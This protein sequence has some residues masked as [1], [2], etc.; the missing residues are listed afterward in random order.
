MFRS[1]AWLAASFLLSAVTFSPAQDT[2]DPLT[3]RQPARRV[4][5]RAAGQ[6]GKPSTARDSAPSES[7]FL[8]E[9]IPAADDAA[10]GSLGTD[11]PDRSEMDLNAVGG[12]AAGKADKAVGGASSD[13]TAAAK[14]SAAPPEAW[15]F[16]SHQNHLW[17]YHP[18]RQW[19]YWDNDHWRTFRPAVASTLPRNDSAAPGYQSGYRGLDRAGAAS[20]KG[21]GAAGGAGS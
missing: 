6:P 10:L 1:A 13:T 21:I 9:D 15:R 5:G 20:G 17:Y 12:P 3:G 16:V 7:T 19:S 18:N 14:A 8:D 2:A 4:E 11:T